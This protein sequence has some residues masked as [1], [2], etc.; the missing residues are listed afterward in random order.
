M[1]AKLDLERER[2]EQRKAVVLQVLI[3]DFER[4][5]DA[6][7]VE[8]LEQLVPQARGA[9]R[10]IFGEQPAKAEWNSSSTSPVSAMS[11]F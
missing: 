7:D 6:G 10:V 2:F 11:S 8:R 3:E 1:S 5:F 4:A 9:L